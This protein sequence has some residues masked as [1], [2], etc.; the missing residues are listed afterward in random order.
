MLSFRVV[1]KLAQGHTACGQA[2]SETGRASSS[3]PACSV[4]CFPA[5][6]YRQAGRGQGDQAIT[7]CFMTSM[8]SHSFDYGVVVRALRG[9]STLLLCTHYPTTM[10][11]VPSFSSQQNAVLLPGL[12]PLLRHLSQA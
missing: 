5:I 2:G 6:V 1:K 8:G 12:A 7:F 11:D 3:T 10:N 9:A 4:C